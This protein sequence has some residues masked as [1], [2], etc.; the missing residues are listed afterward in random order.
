MA[1]VLLVDGPAIA[2]RSHY[3]LA[4]ANLTTVGGQS[5]AATYGYVTTLL[6]L[7]R[8]E[9]PDYTCVAFDLSLIH[10]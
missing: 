4:K 2:Y 7:L 3:G 8:D 5:T 1:K 10:I 9:S 6:K